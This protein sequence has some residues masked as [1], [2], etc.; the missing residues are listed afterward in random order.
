VSVRLITVTNYL[1]K[2]LKGGR[3]MWLMVSVHA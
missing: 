2:Q 1:R 3:F